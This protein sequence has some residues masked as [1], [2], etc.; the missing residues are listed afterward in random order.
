MNNETKINKNVLVRN[1]II[2]SILILIALIVL[3]SFKS[4]RKEETIHVEFSEVKKICELATQKCYYH[5]VM[6]YSE[7]P[8][9]LFK[10]GLF[11]YGY[12]KF[13]IEYNVYATIGIDV[14]KVIINEPDDNNV[15]YVFVPEAK[16]FNVDPDIKSMSKPIVDKG[17]FTTI[18]TDEVTKAFTQ[19]QQEMKNFVKTDE[20]TLNTAHLKAKEIIK[21]YIINVGKQVGQDYTVKWLDAP[22][23][24]IK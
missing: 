21:Q 16:V 12:K 5:T 3:I 11:K 24:D 15:V 23:N 4:F 10:Y 14:S 9:G 8:K 13:W 19:A 20:T 22:N 7:D 17:E 1:I 2:S 6:E 18:T